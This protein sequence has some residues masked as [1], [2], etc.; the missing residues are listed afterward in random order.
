MTRRL[1]ALLRADADPDPSERLAS[2]PSELMLIVPI[3]S[4]IN[5]SKNDDENLLAEVPLTETA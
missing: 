2:F 3:S 5:P 4:R 1:C